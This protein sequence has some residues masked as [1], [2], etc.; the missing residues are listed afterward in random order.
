MMARTVLRTPADELPLPPRSPLQGIPMSPRAGCAVTLAMAA[1]VGL[2]RG[3]ACHIPDRDDVTLRPP[4]LAAAGVFYAVH[5]DRRARPPPAGR[6]R[7]LLPLPS[8]PPASP[9]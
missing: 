1:L 6:P 7:R 5:R 4:S 8:E 9:R 2:V 3:H